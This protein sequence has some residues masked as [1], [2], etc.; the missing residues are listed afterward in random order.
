MFVVCPECGS[1]DFY[2]WQEYT[3]YVYIDSVK[4]EDVPHG[5]GMLFAAKFVSSLVMVINTM[6]GKIKNDLQTLQN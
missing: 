6:K 2:F 4:K 5:G 1:T 3:S